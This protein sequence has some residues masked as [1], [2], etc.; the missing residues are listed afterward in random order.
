MTLPRSTHTATLLPNGTVLVAGGLT[1]SLG[2]I[3][4]T[5]S[6]ELYNPNTGTWSLTNNMFTPRSRFTATLLSHGKVLVEAF[7][8]PMKGSLSLEGGPTQPS[9]MVP[10]LEPGNSSAR[11]QYREV[12]IQ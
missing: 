5:A 12:F 4:T 1:G 9:Y 11:W 6:A 7:Y 8:F 3:V 10:P 2:N